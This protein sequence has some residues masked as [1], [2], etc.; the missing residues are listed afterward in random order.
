MTAIIE[1]RSTIPDFSDPATFS[2]AVPHEAFDRLRSQPGLHWQPTADGTINGGF[3][4]ATRFKDIV[5]IEANTA[6]ITSLKG[7][8]YPLSSLSESEV[9]REF[10]NSAI[11]RMDPPDH[12]RVRRAAAASFGPRVVARFDRWVS[13]IVDEAL[14]QAVAQVEFDWVVDVAKYIPSRVVAR[15]LG[16]QDH[17]VQDIVNWT[18]AIFEAAVFPDAGSRQ[19][20]IGQA[21]FEYA[22]ELQQNKLQAPD[23]DMV[24][25]LSQAVE[26]GDLKQEEYLNYIA[27]LMVAGYET[28]HTLIAQAMRMIVEDDEIRRYAQQAVTDG[29]TD[30]LVDEF[31]RYV[32]PAM[33]MARVATTDFEVDGTQVR[34]DDVIQLMFVAANRDPEV[35]SD[36]HR[37]DPNRCETA[38]LAFGS[39]PHRCIG[40][41][42]AKLELRILF[43]RLAARGVSL[44]LNGEPRR[45]WSAWINQ[46]HSLPVHVV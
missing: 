6:A 20:A 32:T 40:H 33:N 14:D 3:W 1:S 26:R 29:T 22:I 18:D 42:L 5:A 21:V 41:Y 17:R 28:T 36:P 9:E 31:L 39:G 16:V 37:F 11:M 8:F 13:D 10:Q 45:G 46:L 44:R 38:T 4:V 25:V 15:V 19:L 27:L 24:T 43:E 12:S 30:R 7:F 23:D 35:Y 34:K 2:L